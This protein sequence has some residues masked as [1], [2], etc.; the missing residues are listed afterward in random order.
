MASPT[1]LSEHGLRIA[2]EG[3]GHGVLHGIYASVAKAC[4]L[5]GWPGVDLLIIGGDFQA[6]RNASDLKAVSMPTKYYAMHDFHEYYSGARVAPYLTIFIGGNHEASNYMWELY[7]GGWAAPKIYYMGAANI[8][9]LGPLRIAGLSGIW[10]GYN[11]KKPH[12]ERLPYNSDDVRSIY[13]V[14]ELDVRK[15]LQIRTQVDIGLSHDWPRGME[16]KGDFKQ[17]FRWKPDFEQEAKDGTLGSVAATTVLERLRPAHWFSAHMHTKFAGLWE[18][19]QAQ[20][21][22]AEHEPTNG[23]EPTK[24]TEEIQ[25]EV[26]DEEPVA[27]PKNDAEI[28][29]D[30]DDVDEPTAGRAGADT[31]STSGNANGTSEVPQDLRDLLPASFA[32][33]KFEP[34]P[35]L[36]FPSGITNKTTRFLALDKCLPKRSFLQLLE[37]APHSPAQLQRPLQLEYDHEWLAITR[38]FATDL[39]V[40]DPHARVPADK[41]DVHYRPLIEE[42][43]KWVEENVV[44]AGKM[45]IPEDFAQTAEVF[46]PALGIHVQEDPQEYSNPHTQ[47]FCELLQIP[48]AFHASDEERGQMMKNGPRPEEQRSDR[49]GGGRG[50]SRGGHRGRGGGRGRGRGGGGRGGSRGRW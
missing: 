10:K 32:R 30:M 46:E 14:R 23:S 40:G 7:Y 6:V 34:I 11:Y 25:L 28:D 3:C 19:A 37:V 5:K 39:Q 29:L 36:P 49:G 2:V 22:S 13:H 44:K 42:E 18:H 21:A 31:N 4:E 47:A 9:R 8:V 43:M 50:G 48:N 24:N 41:G 1:L 35:T 33:P 20:Y 12:Y 27:A 17:L 45:T 26:P 16:W 15:L 38:V